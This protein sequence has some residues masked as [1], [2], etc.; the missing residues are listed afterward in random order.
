MNETEKQEAA[1]I[2]GKFVRALEE[3]VKAVKAVKTIK[4]LQEKLAIAT[5]ALEEVSAK[6]TQ[7]MQEKLAIATLALE[8]VSANKTQTIYN[9]SEEFMT[10]ANCAF[11]QSAELADEAL[12][13]IKDEVKK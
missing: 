12:D 5:L 1:E 3:A 2:M 10:G 9:S 8:E 11:G 7:T 6:K 4:S 13:K